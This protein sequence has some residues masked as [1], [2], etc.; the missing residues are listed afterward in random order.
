ML[1]ALAAIPVA[2]QP[3]PPL[4]DYINHLATAHVV[5]AISGD[6]DL[7]RFYE[8]DWR[9]I[10]NLMIDLVVPALHRFLSIYV[11]GE[12]FTLAIFVL[13]LTGTLALN[14]ALFGRWSAAP[15]VAAPL[16]YNGVLLVGVMNYVF[17]I[18]L[19]LWAL[20]AWV[21][22]RER[23][24]PQ[25]LLVSTVF[26]LLLYVCH[27]FALGLYA[28]G[29]LAIEIERLWARR[30]EP[31][32]PR[33]A[34]FCATGVPF[35]LAAALL[36]TSETW[37]SHG[38]PAFWEFW[39]KIHGLMLAVS[40]Y[41]DDVAYALLGL[42]ML[43]ALCAAWTNRLHFH[44]VGWALLVVGALVYLAMPRALFAAHLADQRLP[45][46][47]A[48]MLAACLR[49]RSAR[50]ADARSLRRAADYSHGDSRRR[51][52]DSCGTSS[53]TDRSPPMSW[54]S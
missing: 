18:G 28:L 6:P 2:T 51:S 38:V 9:L 27:L 17:G 1:I 34:D 30:S 29:L 8:I 32:W 11:A 48:F 25:R 22:L 4:S 39:G 53:R 45:V 12:I 40:I 42:A 14:R 13:I 24:W 33:F 21:V 15:L 23:A 19:A 31:F 5:D 26:V 3:L 44:P 54:S 52:S 10:P 16:L 20:A 49:R 47:L 35:L 41:Y 46:A 7:Q 37:D 43:A 50:T 36:F